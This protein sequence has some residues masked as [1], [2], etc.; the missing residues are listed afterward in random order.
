MARIQWLQHMRCLPLLGLLSR[1]DRDPPPAGYLRGD[2]SGLRSYDAMSGD[3]RQNRPHAQLAGFLYNPIHMVAFEQCLGEEHG[4]ADLSGTFLLVKNADS[5]LVLRH[6]HH[7]DTI[8][9]SVLISEQETFS[10]FDSKAGAQMMAEIAGE[11]DRCAL[12]VE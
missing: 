11:G 7:L 9:S 8:A 12:N 5:Q 1:L 2:S 4:R 6:F 10:W 3:Q